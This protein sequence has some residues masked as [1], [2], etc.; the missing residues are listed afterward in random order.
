MTSR[1]DIVNRAL[2]AISAQ[3]DIV[4]SAENSKE[5]VAARLLYDPTRQQLLRS[6]HWNFARKT[7]ALTLLKAARG[8]PENPAVGSSVVAWTPEFPSPPWRYEYLVPADCQ[9][10]RFILPQSP[11]VDGW[12]GGGAGVGAGALVNGALPQK[13]VLASDTNPQGQPVNVEL[14]NQPQAI[15]IY[16]ADIA[17]E[18]LWD[19]CFQEAMVYGLASR[20][21]MTLAGDKALA[22]MVSQQAM[23]AVNAA[24][25]SDGN[26][27]LTLAESLPDWLRVRGLAGD[28]SGGACTMGWITPS[29]LLI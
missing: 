15:A 28:C 18:S 27:G 13:F 6:A 7:A 23:L 3:A 17:N 10:I 25:V 21:A 16:T 26:E 20:F 2:A 19:S 9:Q 1:T 4:N 14:S 24:R 8:T 22:R 12:A 11:P 5:A 29:F